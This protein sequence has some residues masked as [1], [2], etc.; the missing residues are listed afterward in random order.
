MAADARTKKRGTF[1]LSYCAG[2]EM[3]IGPPPWLGPDGPFVDQW[4]AQASDPTAAPGAASTRPPHLD[5]P[6][7]TAAFDRLTSSLA[8]SVDLASCG[9]DERA[10][11]P[12]GSLEKRAPMAAIPHN[13]SGKL[14]RDIGPMSVPT[15]TNWRPVHVLRAR[16]AMTAPEIP[17]WCLARM[18]RG[19]PVNGGATARERPRPSHAVAVPGATI[20]AKAD[21]K[22]SAVCAADASIAVGRHQ[23]QPQPDYVTAQ[24][25]P[26]EFVA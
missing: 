10:P 8:A 13:F 26:G 25:G 23:A 14:N 18:R 22:C 24:A 6:P 15:V 3:T 9:Q 4:D 17:P 20:Q 12:G 5:D 19:C 16:P 2:Q 21:F 7:S 11:L 1:G